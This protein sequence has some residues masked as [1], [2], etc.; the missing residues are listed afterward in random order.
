MCRIVP[1]MNPLTVTFIQKY[2]FAKFMIRADVFNYNVDPI[3]TKVTGTQHIPTLY[4]YDQDEKKSKG[5]ITDKNLSQVC[6]TDKSESEIGIVD[7]ISTEESKSKRVHKSIN[8]NKEKYVI[9]EK[10]DEEPSVTDNPVINEPIYF[11]LFGC[12]INP[13]NKIDAMWD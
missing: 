8:K 2:I 3:R 6:S 10:K 11:N 7:E 13:L 12:G 1:I 9:D 4:V 5:I